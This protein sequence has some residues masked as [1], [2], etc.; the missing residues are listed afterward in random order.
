MALGVGLD[1]LVAGARAGAAVDAVGLDRVGS[2]RGDGGRQEEG[3]AGEL[4]GGQWWESDE[5]VKGL[6]MKCWI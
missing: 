6:R 4:H 3:E 1:D 5:E 2:D